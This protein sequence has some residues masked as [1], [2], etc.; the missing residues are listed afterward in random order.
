MI[1]LIPLQ[2]AIAFSFILLI[3]WWILV[4]VFFPLMYLL[5]KKYSNFDKFLRIAWLRTAIT[6]VLSLAL[7]IV[8]AYILLWFGTLFV[9]TETW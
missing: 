3:L 5:L 8:I 4:I 2:A 9:N 1:I 7:A 6:L